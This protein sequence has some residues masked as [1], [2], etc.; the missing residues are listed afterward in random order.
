MFNKPRSLELKFGPILG[1]QCKTSQLYFYIL[2]RM[3]QSQTLWCRGRAQ[4]C[5]L[6][7]IAVFQNWDFHMRPQCVRLILNIRCNSVLV[8]DP[9]DQNEEKSLVSQ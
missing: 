6:N 2:Q 9:Y 8:I 5:W 3:K 1:L 7:P 4:G